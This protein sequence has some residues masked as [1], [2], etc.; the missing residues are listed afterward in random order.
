MLKPV[1]VIA[2][3]LAISC[4]ARAQVPIVQG[5]DSMSRTLD[6]IRRVQDSIR[7]AQDSIHRAQDSIP[8]VIHIEEVGDSVHF[9]SQ[10]RPLR[11]IAGAPAAF[12]TYF[13]ELGDGRFSFD[14][15]PLYAYRDTGI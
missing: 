12:Y 15:E 14:K 9:S 11:H 2:S 7:R 5:K 8:A 3:L 10:L 13:W 6:Y 1:L 4:I